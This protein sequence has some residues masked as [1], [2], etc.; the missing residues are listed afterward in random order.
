VCFSI[1]NSSTRMS[2]SV[3]LLISSTSTDSAQE[4]GQ[5]RI[6]DMLKSKKVMFT[7]LDGS[8][9]ENKERRDQLFACSNLR[10][11]YPQ[12]FIESAATGLTYVGNYDK[13]VELAECDGL[14]GLPDAVETFSKTFASA[15][16]E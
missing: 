16:K 6:H 3:I 13:L 2:D 14:E 1:I 12:V 7:S 11:K 4:V 8:L 5:R 10:G 9:P 15:A